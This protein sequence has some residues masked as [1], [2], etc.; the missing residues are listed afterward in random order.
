MDVITMARELGKAIQSSEEYKKLNT[1]KEIND[2]DE[3]LQKQ[4]EEFN[5]IRVQLST[6]MQDENKDEEKMKTLDG[7]LKG[8]YATVMGNPN[9]LNFNEAKQDI[10]KLMNGI[11][12]ILMACVNGD[13]PDTCEAYPASCD[14]SCSSCGGGCH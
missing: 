14:G 6:L 4:I 12:T 5:M 11:T 8:L 10:D 9:M 3:T 13:D 1:A 2:N 7:E